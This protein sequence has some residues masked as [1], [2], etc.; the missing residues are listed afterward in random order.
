MKKVSKWFFLRHVLKKKVI[1][2][3]KIILFKDQKKE[4]IEFIKR[5]LNLFPKL[6]RIS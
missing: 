2:D 3:R 1:L 6:L 5:D 4:V